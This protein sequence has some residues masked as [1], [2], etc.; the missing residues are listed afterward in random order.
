MKRVPVLLA[1][2]MVALSGC[3]AQN[4]SMK[5]SS[6]KL[7]EKEE[8]VAQL[9]GAD[10]GRIYDYTV[11]GRIKSMRIQLQ[12]M[13]NGQWKENGDSAS[14][15][16]EQTGRIALSGMENGGKP[17]IAYQGKSGGVTSW[18]SESE[19]SGKEDMASMLVWAEEAE[20]VPDQPVVLMLQCF[21]GKEG[22]RVSSVEDYQNVQKLA[23]EYDAANAVV[24]TFSEKEIE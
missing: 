6:K 19:T 22:I 14:E 2:L 18:A 23:D 11:D 9:L 5:I 8:S 20:I 13:E 16:S 24:I 12:T 21:S 3:G 7:T 10:S 4:G 17:R 1:A 15:V